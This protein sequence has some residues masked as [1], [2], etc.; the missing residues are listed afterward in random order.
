M[1]T[2]NQG[3]VDDNKSQEKIIDDITHKLVSKLVDTDN[4]NDQD[5]DEIIDNLTHKLV[6]KLLDIDDTVSDSSE[7]SEEDEDEYSQSKRI[8]K[9]LEIHNKFLIRLERRLN[10]LESHT[11]SHL[12]FP[13]Y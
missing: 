8:N 12:G 2:S 9:L 3:E 11:F 6:A 5:H 10:K 7:I 13:T 4:N 1:D